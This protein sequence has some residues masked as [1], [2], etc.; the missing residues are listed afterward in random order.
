MINLELSDE[1]V[2][3]CFVKFVLSKSLFLSINLNGV[4]GN[5]LNATIGWK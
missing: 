1:K 4:A 2:Y 3:F 5:S